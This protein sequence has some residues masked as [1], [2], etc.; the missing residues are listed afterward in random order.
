MSERLTL[1]KRGDVVLHQIAYQYAGGEG[2]AGLMYR[3]LPS[4]IYIEIE[5]ADAAGR[6]KG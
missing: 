5:V 4:M 1:L 2:G 3:G 6:Q